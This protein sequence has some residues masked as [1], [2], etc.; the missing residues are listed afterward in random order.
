M[1]DTFLPTIEIFALLTIF[2]GEVTRSVLCHQ[3]DFH[4]VF[5]GLNQTPRWY[6]FHLKELKLFSGRSI[7]N[8]QS[9][10]SDTSYIQRHLGKL[11]IKWDDVSVTLLA[12][13]TI[14]EAEITRSVSWHSHLG[15]IPSDRVHLMGAGFIHNGNGI[16]FDPRIGIHTFQHALEERKQFPISGNFTLSRV[17]DMTNYLILKYGQYTKE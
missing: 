10:I 7:R 2:G 11:H 15:Q 3:H 14:P 13:F 16:M 6:W 4:M 9:T 17:V 1:G 8:M 12:L 5:Y